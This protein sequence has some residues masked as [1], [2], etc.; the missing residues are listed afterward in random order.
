MIPPNVKQLELMEGWSEI[1]PKMRVRFDFPL[2]AAAGTKTTAVVYFEIEP[3]ERL[4]R[5]T[6]S[7]EEI[8]YVVEGSGEA[9]VGGERVPIEAGSLAVVPELVPHGVRNTGDSTLKVV[10]FFSAAELEHVFEEPLQP[11]GVTVVHTPFVPAAV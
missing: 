6:D 3:G 8:L 2:Q 1:D 9:E 7:A 5:H 11:L 10:G 4:A